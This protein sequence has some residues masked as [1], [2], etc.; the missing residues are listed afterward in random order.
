MGDIVAF[1]DKIV[2]AINGVVW[3]PP[4]LILLLGTHIFLTVRLKF[5]QMHVFKAIKM[6]F[7]KD[8]GMGKFTRLWAYIPARMSP[9]P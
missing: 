1:I 6:I 2:S 5:I 7:R 8:K 9:V 3:G 4:M